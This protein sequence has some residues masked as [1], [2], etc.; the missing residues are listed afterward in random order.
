MRDFG[1]GRVGAVI[2]VDTAESASPVY[3]AFFIFE[4]VGDRWLISDWPS[5][6]DIEESDEG[7]GIDGTTMEPTM[8]AIQAPMATLEP[9]A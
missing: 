4:R 7:D 8:E 1:D 9:G 2:A 6:S 5:T 3:P